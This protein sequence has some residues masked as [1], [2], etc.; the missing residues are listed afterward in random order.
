MSF[1][2]IHNRDVFQDICEK[3]CEIMNQLYSSKLHQYFK[4]TWKLVY[5]RINKN[6][7]LFANENEDPANGGLN[8]KMFEQCMS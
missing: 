8:A 3:Y 6:D 1:L 4:D 2:K 7:I 5:F